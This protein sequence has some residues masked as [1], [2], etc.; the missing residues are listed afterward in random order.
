MK[1]LAWFILTLACIAIT[2]LV[3]RRPSKTE[4]ISPLQSM[5]DRI[6]RLYDVA[7]LFAAPVDDPE[8]PL[9]VT[10]GNVGPPPPIQPPVGANRGI[11]VSPERF[12][13]NQLTTLITAGV[14]PPSWLNRGASI[15]VF[16]R[17]LVIVQT[18][19]NQQL[20]ADLLDQLRKDSP[21]HV[22]VEAVWALLTQENLEQLL[23]QHHGARGYSSIDPQ[24]LENLGKAVAWRGQVICRS[25]EQ[26]RISCG[27]T[28]TILGLE[29]QV[30]DG[31][32]GY[33]ARTQ[34]LLDGAMLEVT[35][36]LD[37][38]ASHV[39]LELRSE[40]TQIGANSSPPIEIPAPLSPL[41]PVTQPIK[42]DRLNLGVQQLSTSLRGPSGVM[43]YAGGTLNPSAQ[44]GDAR[45]L[46]LFI[47]ATQAGKAT[48]AH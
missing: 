21:R 4:S 30:G 28:R 29:S 5:G 33:N 31:I 37:G 27:Q 32:A 22:R 2:W 36:S 47:R 11:P 24:T 7:D 13:M 38:D 3:A 16:G 43:L 44:P 8:A 14:D 1:R 20:I 40:V 46:Y 15:T 42:L 41:S 6:V 9:I 17:H 25:G 26:T 39:Q 12:R 10:A 18:R 23:K 48:N 35:P 45:R 34:Q 19:Q